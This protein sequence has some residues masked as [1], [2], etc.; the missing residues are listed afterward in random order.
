MMGEVASREGEGARG[1]VLVC[2]S[3]DPVWAPSATSRQ[4]DGSD[5]WIEWDAG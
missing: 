1:A 2:D 4:G 5:G 3:G